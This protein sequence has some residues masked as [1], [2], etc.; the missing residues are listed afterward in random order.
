MR[1]AACRWSELL[2]LRLCNAMN[3]ATCASLSNPA[4]MP[5]N[6]TELQEGG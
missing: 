4:G 1:N 3:Q 6:A 5:I 2:L